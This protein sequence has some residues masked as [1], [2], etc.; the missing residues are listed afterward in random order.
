MNTGYVSLIVACYNNSPETAGSVARSSSMGSFASNNSFD[1]FYSSSY[2][3]AGS[4]SCGSSCGGGS[5][6]A[7]G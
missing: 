5:F 2:S 4:S 6:T 1:G 7:V 3:S